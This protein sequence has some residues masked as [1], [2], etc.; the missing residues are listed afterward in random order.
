MAGINPKTGHAA[1][2]VQL[3]VWVSKKMS[4]RWDRFA[5]E[6]G[7][8]RTSLIQNAVEAYIIQ[9]ASVGVSRANA[10]VTEVKENFQKMLGILSQEVER[11]EEESTR[12]SDPRIRSAILKLIEPVAGVKATP[13][14]FEDIAK[15]LMLD[16]PVIADV[17]QEMKT[18]GLIVIDA[19]GCVHAAR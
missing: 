13:R 1:D 14:K 4:E 16:E 5:A 17:I 7:Y 19:E 9:Q 11:K 10:V 6:N 15:I 12:G 8:S 18:D 3:R 2:S